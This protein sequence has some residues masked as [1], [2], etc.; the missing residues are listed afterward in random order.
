MYLCRKFPSLRSAATPA[1]FGNKSPARPIGEAEAQGTRANV[2]LRTRNGGSEGTMGHG[3]KDVPRSSAALY[4]SRTPPHLHISFFLPLSS[5]LLALPW[6][7]ILSLTLLTSPTRVL[8]TSTLS[9]YFPSSYS[10]RAGPFILMA[11]LS[12]TSTKDWEAGRVFLYSLSSLVY[13]PIHAAT[14]V[15]TLV[16]YYFTLIRPSLASH[17]HA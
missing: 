5:L 7:C 1:C 9:A 12:S 2:E 15:V 3:V 8:P 10:H 14:Q 11:H 4:S 6:G 16:T 17:S 13:W